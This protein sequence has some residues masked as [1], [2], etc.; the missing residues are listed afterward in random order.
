MICLKQTRTRR[1]VEITRRVHFAEGT[2][3]CGGLTL[4]P[5][6][7]KAYVEFR[8]AHAFPVM[9]KDRTAFHPQVV[10][11]SHASMLH[12]VFNL[13]H[14]MK[15]NE[16]EDNAI[17]RDRI[18]GS[19]V[20]VE[21]PR[22]PAMGWACQ[23]KRSAAPGIRAVAVLHKRAEGVARIMGE[24]HSGRRRWSVS[25]EAN[26]SLDASGFLLRAGDQ[27]RS[28]DKKRWEALKEDFET[29]QDLLELGWVYVPCL[30]APEE[31]LDCLETTDSLKMNPWEGLETVILVGGLDGAV[32]FK[33]VAMA[34]LGTQKEEEAR[35]ANLLA[36]E[37][38][39]EIE[40]DEESPAG[41]VA[42]VLE[43]MKGVPEMWREKT[44]TRTD[45]R[46]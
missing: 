33:G 20:A 18:L 4:V 3:E 43:K 6:A 22:T 11:N 2:I 35:I 38:W 8:L 36:A 25:L 10:D 30:K 28:R 39:T 32:H 40:E 27:S 12:Q 29:P 44:G 24:H 23:E 13:A 37:A 26:L 7:T 42:S 17:A 19:I 34:P 31:L 45:S 5:D 15:A 16:T 41:D 21:Y 1:G 46:A 14:L 9:S